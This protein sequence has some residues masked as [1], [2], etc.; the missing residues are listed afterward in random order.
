M[1]Q[2]QLIARGYRV[3]TFSC[4]EEAAAYLTDAIRNT[5]VGIGGSVTVKEMGLYE[6]LSGQ[7]RVLWHWMPAEGKTSAELL[8]EARSTEVYLSSVNALAETGEIVNIDGN[9]NRV[10]EIFYG[11]KKVYLIVGKNKIAPSLEEAVKRARNV[12]APLNAKRLNRKTPCAVK[13]DRCYDCDSPDRIC[14]G[15]QVLLRAPSAAVYEIILV[16][17][18]IGY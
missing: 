11:H 1:I 7:N 10:A 16:D 12:A 4:K 17:E 2:E 3:S 14:R 15:V 9:G 13:G 8:T 6:L 5:T 18:V